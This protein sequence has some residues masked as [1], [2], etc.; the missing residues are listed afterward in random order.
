MAGIDDIGWVQQIGLR[1][2]MQ[3]HC[4]QCTPARVTTTGTP[5]ER[6]VHRCGWVWYE[7]IYVEPETVA[8]ETRGAGWRQYCRLV[9]QGLVVALPGWVAAVNPPVVIDGG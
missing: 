3:A 7:T 9:E 2:S 6:I 5:I 1:E 4:P 8:H